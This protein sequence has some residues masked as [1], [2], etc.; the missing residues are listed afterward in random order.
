[1]QISQ[2]DPSQATQFGSAH[3]I[4]HGLADG[5]QVVLLSGVVSVDLQSPGWVNEAAVTG[6]F[7]D[8]LSLDIAL[9]SGLL[10][11]GQSFRLLESVPYLSINAMAG[12]TN[13]GWGVNSFA[14]APEA[15]AVN[16]VRL[17]AELSVSRTGEIL[18]RVGYH[19]TL[20]GEV[21]G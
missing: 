20:I 18:H 11:D 14:M 13:V 9:P 17:N 19:I 15:A 2:L 7:S 16:S 21:I 12:V 6:W 8:Q 3:A 10:R 1:M 5:R 4:H